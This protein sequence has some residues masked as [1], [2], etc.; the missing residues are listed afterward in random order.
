MIANPYSR[1]ITRENETIIPFECK[2]SKSD[3]EASLKSFQPKVVS[4]VK[5]TEGKAFK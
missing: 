3:L 1:V 4:V 2:Y 5:A